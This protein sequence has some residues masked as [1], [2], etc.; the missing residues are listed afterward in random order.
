MPIAIGTA[1]TVRLAIAL[2]M[3]V[4][5]AG[6]L[7][8]G[9][10]TSGVGE[11]SQG[12]EHAAPGSATGAARVGA[13]PRPDSG[14]RAMR[15]RAGPRGGSRTSPE[16]DA[17][18]RTGQVPSHPPIPNGFTVLFPVLRITP[19]RSALPAIEVARPIPDEPRDRSPAW[20]GQAAVREQRAGRSITNAIPAIQ[21]QLP[22]QSLY[23][24]PRCPGL[25]RDGGEHEAQPPRDQQPTDRVVGPP[26][27]DQR[28][29][30]RARADEHEGSDG[31]AARAAPRFHELS[32]T[33]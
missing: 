29:D 31:R 15:G 28:T 33:M 14:A 24:V 21:I 8:T 9:F 22:S 20:A 7:T 12:H 26:R 30:G 23:R 19:G 3:S 17:S 16:R 1:A 32:P 27:R 18:R 13:G 25:D 2:P 4:A 6:S 5:V 10:G 11:D